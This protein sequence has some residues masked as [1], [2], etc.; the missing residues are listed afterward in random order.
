MIATADQVW[1][2][3][4]R[5]EPGQTSHWPHARLRTG[6]LVDLRDVPG[7]EAGSHDDL[8]VSGFSEGAARVVNPRLG[9]SFRLGWD[10]LV[11]PWVVLWQPYGGAVDPSLAGSY[12]LGIEPWTARHCLADAIDAGVATW[13][14]PGASL[15]TTVVAAIEEIG[16]A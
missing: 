1:E 14:D 10:E 15:S 4:A 11:F 12:A 5:L 8:F 3:T 16:D 2:E 13:L 9:L 7:P 6:G